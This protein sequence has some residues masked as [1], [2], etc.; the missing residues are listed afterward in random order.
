MAPCLLDTGQTQPSGIILKKIYNYFSN[1]CETWPMKFMCP[2]FAEFFV[3]NIKLISTKLHTI[4]SGLFKEK[5]MI[6]RRWDNKTAIT[7]MKLSRGDS[8]RFI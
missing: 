7:H 4:P 5:E 3:L 6:L 1:R 2:R 8:E